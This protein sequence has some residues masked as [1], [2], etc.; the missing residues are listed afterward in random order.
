MAT[1]RTSH[2]CFQQQVLTHIGDVQWKPEEESVAE[3]L[4]KQQTQ[5]ELHHTLKNS[6]PVFTPNVYSAGLLKGATEL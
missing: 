2:R 5:R 6:E 3:K 1:A 4:R